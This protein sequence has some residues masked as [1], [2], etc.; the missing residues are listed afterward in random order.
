M[1]FIVVFCCIYVMRV[2]YQLGESDT[3]GTTNSCYSHSAKLR[4][5]LVINCTDGV[6]I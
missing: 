4:E 5:E 2:L 6:K 3:V 1:S